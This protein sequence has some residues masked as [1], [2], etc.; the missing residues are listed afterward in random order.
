MNTPFQTL[1]QQEI[2]QVAGGVSNHEKYVPPQPPPMP[3]S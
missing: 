3:A 2:D 1:T